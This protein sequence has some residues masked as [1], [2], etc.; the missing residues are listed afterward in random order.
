MYWDYFEQL[1]RL[2]RPG[3]VIVADNVLWYGRVADNE[4]R[5]VDSLLE[6]SS[7]PVQF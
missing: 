1:L 7:L 5:S 2:L 3:G 6:F 4:V